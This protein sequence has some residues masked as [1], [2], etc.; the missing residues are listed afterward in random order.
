MAQ[1]HTDADLLAMEPSSARRIVANR[2]AAARAK[3]RKARF[4][5]ALEDHQRE[6]E[7][8]LASLQSEGQSLSLQILQLGEAASPRKHARLALTALTSLAAQSVLRETW[9]RRRCSPRSR[10][11]FWTLRTWLSGSAQQCWLLASWPCCCS[12]RL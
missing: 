11:W 12:R 6:L 3:R 8:Q 7:R 1:T 2:Q 4:V 10:P 5:G 9:S